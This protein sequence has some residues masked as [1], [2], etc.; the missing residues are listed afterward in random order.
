MYSMR[1]RLSAQQCRERVDAQQA[2][3]HCLNEE[4]KALRAERD[5]AEAEHVA[6]LKALQDAH[7]AE[8]QAVHQLY[9]EKASM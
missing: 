5:R 4:I 9:A 6:A 2:S 8:L 3:L 7:A 1:H